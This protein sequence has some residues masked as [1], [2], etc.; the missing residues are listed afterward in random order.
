MGEC[1]WGIKSLMCFS[2]QSPFLKL[3]DQVCKYRTYCTSKKFS[4]KYPLL[5]SNILRLRVTTFPIEYRHWKQMLEKW[6]FTLCSLMYS[7]IYSLRSVFLLQRIKWLVDVT[8]ISLHV[9]IVGLTPPPKI[10]IVGWS[11]F[12]L[13]VLQGSYTYFWVPIKEFY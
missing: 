10:A 2:I 3:C 12:I 6:P 5:F 9:I 1:L 7:R 4:I 13:M 8:H 11:C